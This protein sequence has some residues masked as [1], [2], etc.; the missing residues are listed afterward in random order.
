VVSRALR[1]GQGTSVADGFDPGEMAIG[2]RTKTEGEW[3]VPAADVVELIKNDHRE[4]ERLFDLL[5]KQPVTR[6]LNFPVLCALLIAHSRAE[7]SEV[8]PVA[9]SE[10][11]ETDEVAH[12]QGEHAEAEHM[13]E[14]M[15]AM[16]P[17]SAEFGAALEELI[18]SVN[19]HVEEEESRVLPGMQ[20]RLSED[21]RAELAEAF[22]TAPDRASRGPAGSS[23]ARRPGASGA[24]RR[25]QRYKR[26]LEERA[27]GRSL[28][29][30]ATEW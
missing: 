11:G 3:D 26:Q 20:Q 29:A 9:K 15:T 6:S 22:V 2:W 19:H 16:D 13:L 18:K 7:E 23:V 1:Q 5:Q 14:Q 10:A 4:V 24:Q 8:Y 27:Q 30:C 12:S 28:G 21:R 25:A 17:E